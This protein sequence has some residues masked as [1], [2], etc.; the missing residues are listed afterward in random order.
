MEVREQFQ[1][2]IKRE[3]QKLILNEDANV[4]EHWSTLKTTLVQVAEKTLE[5]QK[6]M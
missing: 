2:N 6:K 3:V 1:G 4:Q 5:Y